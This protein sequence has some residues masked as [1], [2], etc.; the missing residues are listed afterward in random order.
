MM[1]Q[2]CSSGR[3]QKVIGLRE[4][5][6]S[7]GRCHKPRM[8]PSRGSA[9]PGRQRHD[10]APSSQQSYRRGRQ[11]PAAAAPLISDHLMQDLD[12]P[13]RSVHADPLPIPD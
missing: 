11:R 12:V 3:V 9:A 6:P 1:P 8:R 7:P 2:T 4:T 13:V 10:L 5:S